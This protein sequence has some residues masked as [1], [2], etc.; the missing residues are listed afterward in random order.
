MRPFH[1]LVLLALIL[2]IYRRLVCQMARVN[3]WQVSRTHI[4]ALESNCGRTLDRRAISFSRDQVCTDSFYAENFRDDCVS[5]WF[6][7]RKKTT[8]IPALETKMGK[9]INEISRKCAI[10]F[11][12]N[13]GIAYINAPLHML[14]S[15]YQC[16]ESSAPPLY[17]VRNL[18]A[19]LTSRPRA[20]ILT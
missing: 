14:W 8:H 10:F 16:F 17:S 7:L 20:N 12:K 13:D 11:T 3:A 6:I 19:R 5:K 4:E 9:W 15:F 2:K 18:I 1:D